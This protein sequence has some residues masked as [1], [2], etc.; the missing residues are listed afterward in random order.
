MKI[1]SFGILLISLVSCNE[2][3]QY[4]YTDKPLLQPVS[5]RSYS[6]RNLIADA[7]VDVLW[8]VDNSGSMST[9]QQNIVSNS[10]LFMNDFIKDNI[11]QWKMGV[12]STSR[13][14]APYLGFNLD[15]DPT[16]QNPVQMFQSAINSLGTSGDP[17]EYLF[18]N[19]LRAKTD[20]L[21]KSFFRDGAHLAVIMV[22]DEPEQSK[23]VFGA[24]YEVPAFLN[25]LSSTMN[26]DRILRFYGA[27]DY[28]DLNG[29][30]SM[31]SY[32][33]SPVEEVIND[34]LGLHMSACTSDFGRQLA[35]IGKD[36][37]SIVDTPQILLNELPLINTIKVM[38][39]NVELQGGA[40]S[41]GGQWYYDEVFNK[42]VFYSMDFIP[43]DILDPR[44]EII[45][46]IDDGY[47]RDE[48]E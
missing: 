39:Q 47:N 35:E 43:E 9:I 36:I 44:I 41:L 13:S 14:E 40:R 31:T 46:D 22:T 3:G 5:S 30:K 20:P 26:S 23:S 34:T 42:I 28:G 2:K 29:C 4:L 7:K 18:Y 6:V 12:M 27:F 1:L 10:A 37:L 32:A 21:L 48:I 45:F 15:F 8:V 19:V 11:M 24:Q 16:T 33:G 38:F 25:A 17:S